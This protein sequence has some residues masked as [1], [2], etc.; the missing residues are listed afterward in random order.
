MNKPLI[1]ATVAGIVY[2]LQM[3]VH[4]PY[5]KAISYSKCSCTSC[6]NLRAPL[7]N[8]GSAPEQSTPNN[9]PNGHVPGG[10]HHQRWRAR[11]VYGLITCVN[12]LAEQGIVKSGCPPPDTVYAYANSWNV[13]SLPPSCLTGHSLGVIFLSH[14]Q[15]TGTMDPTFNPMITDDS[16]AFSEQAVAVLEK[17]LS[18]LSLPTAT[19]YWK[20]LTI[21]I[22]L[23]V[24]R[25]TTVFAGGKIP[26]VAPSINKNQVFPGR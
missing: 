5:R 18:N 26:L 14:H 25:E 20:S 4:K 21:K 19:S 24:K 3:S 15:E 11:S 13:S 12:R 7:A 9:W 2:S 22:P 10:S 23:P 17:E 1:A 6:H 16:A 8:N